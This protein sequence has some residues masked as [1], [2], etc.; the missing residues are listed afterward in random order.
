MAEAEKDTLTPAEMRQWLQQELR[1]V[2]KATELRVNDAV[3]FVNAYSNGQLTQEQAMERFRTYSNRWGDAIRGVNT[4]A[5]MKDGDI[6]ARLD[7]ARSGRT[8]ER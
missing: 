1:D 7:R 2:T 5:E 4:D 3:D 6:L 8:W